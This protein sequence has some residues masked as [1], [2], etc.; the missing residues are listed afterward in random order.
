MPEI[1]DM[2]TEHRLAQAI[3][4]TVS[5]LRRDRAISVNEASAVVGVTR[6]TWRRWEAGDVCIPLYALYRISQY[7]QVPIFLFLLKD[8]KLTD[9]FRRLERLEREMALFKEK[10]EALD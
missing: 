7:F 5:H 1:I 6:K 3:G 10:L 8:D 2:N 4:E 9:F